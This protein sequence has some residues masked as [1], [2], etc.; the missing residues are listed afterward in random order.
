MPAEIAR[1]EAAVPAVPTAATVQDFIVAYTMVETV[2]LSN[3]D[4]AGS[5]IDCDRFNAALLAAYNYLMSAKLVLPP[6]GGLVIDQNLNRWMLMLARYYLDSVRRRPDVTA[7]YKA[8]L[9]E[10]E[11]LRELKGFDGSIEL[12]DGSSSPRVYL[13]T[14]KSPVWTEQST[15]KYKKR[16]LGVY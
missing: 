6:V 16:D 2:E 8:V 14:G 15:E 11:K 5:Y 9:D 12:P 3:L 4:S 1:C 10:I 7:D 13:H